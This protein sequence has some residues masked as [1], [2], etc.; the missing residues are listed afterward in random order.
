VLQCKPDVVL[1]GTAD[2]LA[3]RHEVEMPDAIG[4]S[5]VAGLV[6]KL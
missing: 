4:H 5:D 3:G 1:G 6:S 2:E